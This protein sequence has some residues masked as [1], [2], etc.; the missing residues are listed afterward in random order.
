MEKPKKKILTGNE[1]IARGA[2]EY[3][4]EVAA[5]Y[6]G[7]PSSEILENVV[8]YKDHVYCQWSP[9]E[10]VAFETATGA[11][12]SGRRSMVTMKHVGLNVAADPF[13]TVAYSGI[14]GAFVIISADDP[15]MHSSQN[16]QDNRNYAKFAKIPMLEPSDSQEAKDF[17]GEAIK[18]SEEFDTPVMLRVTTRTCH[19]KSIV[20]LNDTRPE[21]K[22]EFPPRQ[23]QKYVMIPAHAKK[24]RLIMKER[25]EKLSKYSE[26]SKLNVEEI[27]DKEIGIITNGISYQYIKEV[28]PKASVLKLGMTNPLP[29]QKIRKF[30]E[31]VKKCYVVEE[32]D[33]FMEEQIKSAGIKV[34]GKEVIPEIGELNPEI[35][36]KSITG[37]D[38][39]YTNTVAELKLPTRPP[40]LCPGCPHRG[41]YV[42]LKK[43]KARVSGDI[44]CY[45]LGVLPPLSSLDWQVCMGAGVSMTLGIEK[46]WDENVAEKLVGVIGDSTFIHSGITGLID[47]VYNKGTSTI[48]I[49]DNRITAMTG[50]QEHPATG[51]TLMGEETHELNLVELVKA[52]GIKNVEVVDPLDLPELEKILKTE[53]ARREPS[54]VITRRKCVLIDKE[55][56]RIPLEVDPE[57]C[58]GCKLCLAVGCLALS[59]EDKKTKVDPMLCTGCMVCARQCNF[60]AFKQNGTYLEFKKQK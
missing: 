32:L 2:Y 55:L 17:M 20:T 24:R 26:E 15:G 30:T 45:T 13:F 34:I 59:F 50:R 29:M 46:G 5:G 51:K 31:T 36:Y 19:S 8:L 42:V 52:V 37:K 48:I 56:K 60:G 4:I 1:A 44:G 49:M 23:S 6:P 43:L 41:V 3:G 35:I 57:K 10:K 25:L 54:V 9:N 53:M 12:F 47:M 21:N 33:P 58:T 16:E 14:E 38:F 28:F 11:A 7:T 40:A 18:I 22:K 39:G 27:N